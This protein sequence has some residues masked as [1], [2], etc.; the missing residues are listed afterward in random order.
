[1]ASGAGLKMITPSAGVSFAA[2][3]SETFS[4]GGVFTTLEDRV[5]GGCGRGTNETAAFRAVCPAGTRIV[6]GAESFSGDWPGFK[7]KYRR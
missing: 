2:A 4:E 1:M 5:G 6:F 7:S 3:S